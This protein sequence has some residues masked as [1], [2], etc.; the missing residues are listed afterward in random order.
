[1]TMLVLRV[2][3]PVAVVLM[4]DHCSTS[5]NHSCVIV[6]T[7]VV[8]C[9]RSV[10]LLVYRHWCCRLKLY[11]SSL[12]VPV[13]HACNIWHVL[14]LVL[15]TCCKAFLF[16]CPVVVL[17]TAFLVQPVLFLLTVE[18]SFSVDVDRSFRNLFLCCLSCLWTCL[19]LFLCIYLCWWL[20]CPSVLFLHCSLLTLLMKG[21][22]VT[23]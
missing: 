17:C 12:C 14:F 20:L 15:L 10:H 8:L 6:R 1:M 21:S 18:C 5:V 4:I 11:N 13:D 2:L 16:L 9:Q 23:C 3:L 22:V 19:F 7:T